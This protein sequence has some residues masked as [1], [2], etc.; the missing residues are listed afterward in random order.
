MMEPQVRIQELTEQL[1]EYSRLYYELDAPVITD[2]E[3]DMLLQELANLEAQYPEFALENSPTKRVGGRAVEAF[4][5][6][7]HTVPM[8]SLGNG[9]S[10]DDLRDFDIRVQKA[11]GHAVTYVAEPK[12]DGLAVSL[13]YENGRLVEAATRGD[14]QVGEDITHNAMTIRDLPKTIPENR[15]LIVRGEIYMDKPGFYALNE[16]REAEGLQPFM[17]PRNAAAGS[18]RQLDPKVTAE[19][20]LRV[21]LYALGSLSGGAFTSHYEFLNYLKENTFPVQAMSQRFADMESLIKWIETFKQERFNLPYD[22]DGVVIKVDDLHLQQELGFTSKVPRWAIAYKF[23]PEEKETQ[24]LSIDVQVGR[25]GALTPAANLTPVILA[26]T[27]VSRATLH[28]EDFIRERDIR[29]GDTVVV[30]KAGEIIPEV[31]RVVMEKR[32]GAEVPFHMPDRCPVCGAPTAREDNG[33]VLRC[34]NTLGCP[35]QLSRGL[36]HFVSK[37]AMDIDGLGPKVIEQLL[38]EGLIHSAPDLYRLKKEELTALDRMGEKSA[39]NLITAIEKSKSAGLSSLLHALGIPLLGE[40]SAKDLAKA[41]GSMERVLQMKEEDFTAIPDFGEKTAKSILDYLAEP[42]NRER[43][44]ELAALGV[45]ME[46]ERAENASQ[47][48]MGKTVVITGTLK[49]FSREEAKAAVENA[50]GKAAGSVSKKT[51]YVVAGEAAGSKLDKA[52]QLGVPVL[53]E[54]AFMRLLSTGQV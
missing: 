47:V 36:Q 17:N 46:E 6:V 29:V 14:G 45:K 26:G 18:V 25:T 19:R 1:L 21:F 39:D 40:R 7:V 9:Y 12:I 28:N 3:F 32:T 23:P 20:P 27:T 2:Y 44:R 13:R 42:Q 49:N 31:L 16:K 11:V 53:D 10:Y 5:E 37:K 38:Q 34:T 50:G 52:R 15:T 35:A 43:I 41:A 22:T 24:L 54:E 4:R 30:R 51:H 33:A 48:L 8:M